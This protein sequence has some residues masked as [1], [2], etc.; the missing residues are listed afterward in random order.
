MGT[1][2][3]MFGRSTKRQFGRGGKSAAFWEVSRSQNQLFFSR[4][5]AA[6]DQDEHYVYAIAL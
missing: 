1:D 3:Q 2:I 4:W 5:R 6:P